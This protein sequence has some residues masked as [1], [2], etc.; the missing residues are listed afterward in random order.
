MRILLP[1]NELI[2]STV[3]SVVWKET[4]QIVRHIL[5]NETDNLLERH[6]NTH[7]KKQ[8]DMHVSFFQNWINFTSE[9][10]GDLSSFKEWYP[11][12]GSSEGI[13][14]IIREASWKDETLIVFDGE[15]EGYEAIASGQGTNIIKVD[16]SVW[17]ETLLD[18]K[19][20]GVPWK[21]SKAQWWISN[22]SAID[23]NYWSDF[24]DWLKEI[25][26]FH[27]QIKVWLDLTYVGAAYSDKKIFE[28]G[29]PE[30]V[31]GVVFSLSKVM[32]A[33]YRRIGGV[34]SR[35]T[36]S[37]LWGNR[38][39][40][41]L[42][43]LYIGERWFELVG[44]CLDNNRWV[45]KEEKRSLKDFVDSKKEIQH[46]VYEKVID[47]MGGHSKLEG[48]G[49]FWK[50]SDV[51]LLMHAYAFQ[52]FNLGYDDSVWWKASSRDNLGKHHRLCLS[53]GIAK[54]GFNEVA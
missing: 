2:V 47:F 10:V 1:Q 8:D 11:T 16:R 5:K 32:G 14:E 34:L 37:G 20:N 25:G 54:W 41:N 6:K 17:K 27:G 24:S 23:G 53:P 7:L 29:V 15:Y 46:V 42:D 22:P 19:K 3:Y 52:G 30:V 40:K 38:W 45:F 18:W 9:Q 31:S 33:Y 13:R 51:V 49:C 44:R 4:E 35:E 43:S 12:A 21:T 39:F 28:F 26:Y 50:K 48:E 36:I